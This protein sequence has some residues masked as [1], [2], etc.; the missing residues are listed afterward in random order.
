M[1]LASFAKHPVSLILAL[2]T[3]ILVI[4][5]F[6]Y[7]ML[8]PPPL[9][10]EQRVELATTTL[11]STLQTGTLVT[12]P[13]LRRMPLPEVD[14]AA[15]RKNLFLA[16]LLPAVLEENAR[17][18]AQRKLAKRAKP[19][20]S[21]YRKLAK[22]YGLKSDVT[23]KRL[24]R[25]VHIIP[26]SLALAQAALES[27]WGLSRFA[28]EGTAFFGQRTFDMDAPGIPPQDVN[29]D[30]TPFLVKSFKSP[31]ASVRSYMKTL[32]THDAYKKLRQRR[33]QLATQGKPVSGMALVPFLNSYSEIGGK[34]MKR[35]TA[36]IQANKL[37]LFDRIKRP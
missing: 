18:Q 15:Q 25:R 33:E 21:D 16:A 30:A 5:W 8:L 17:I 19:K 2:S 24:L 34:Y 29:P 23:R 32:N 10:I 9:S 12:D 26:P 6:G 3:L 36:T 13:A 7:Q 22:A 14:S 28:R 35:I 27:G 37:Q 11:D 31:K 20:S 1:N 4:L